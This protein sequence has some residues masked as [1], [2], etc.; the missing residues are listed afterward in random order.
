MRRVREWRLPVRYRV[1]PRNDLIAFALMALAFGLM[2]GLAIAPGWGNAGS[3]GPIITLP[4]PESVDTGATGDT[5]TTTVASLQPPAGGESAPTSDSTS[6]GDTSSIPDLDTGTDTSSDLADTEPDPE[7]DPENAYTDP[8]PD[9]VDPDPAP[10]PQPG[11]IATVVG[12]DDAGYAVAD[13]SGNLLFV[14]YRTQ[15]PS[16][17]QVGAKVGTNIDP[18]ANGSFVQFGGLQNESRQAASKI[19]GVVSWVDPD[20]GVITISARGASIAVD[21]AAATVA[22]GGTPPI[23][24]WV[25][26]KVA[27]DGAAAKAEEPVAADEDPGVETGEEPEAEE[28]LTLPT[29]IA[30]SIEATGEPGSQIEL[31][32]PVSWDPALAK[33]FM[34]ADGFGV[35]NREIELAVPRKLKLKGILEGE[36]YA[37]T[38]DVAADGSLRLAGLSAN[39]SKEAA[40]DPA[41][42]FGTHSR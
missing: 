34:A 32:G 6:S 37:A 27:F 36:I 19:N 11:L 25:T 17:P 7:P 3:N 9:P 21:V 33:L 23:G 29:T 4:P 30:R 22:A 35:L 15:G 28:P 16:P 31:S 40:D 14:H 38:A 10:D 20:A 13:G 24:T 1:P 2:V 12:V 18:L 39:Y 42:A 8:P 5:G 26:G 41:Q